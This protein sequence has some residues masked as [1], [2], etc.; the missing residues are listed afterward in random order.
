MQI[1]ILESFLHTDQQ[2]ESFLIGGARSSS[3]VFTG[4]IGK[5]WRRGDLLEILHR[6][7]DCLLNWVHIQYLRT[8]LNQ[9]I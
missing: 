7:K 1:S 5:T 6:R 3:C 8:S 9:Q 4:K 2:T